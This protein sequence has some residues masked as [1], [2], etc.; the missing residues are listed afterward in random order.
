MA[1]RSHLFQLLLLA[2]ERV[3]DRLLLVLQAKNSTVSLGNF[4]SQGLN[5]VV[6]LSALLLELFSLQIVCSGRLVLEVGVAVLEL[7]QLTVLVVDLLLHHLA[8]LLQLVQDVVQVA[9]HGGLLVFKSIISI[10][11]VIGELSD[12]ILVFLDGRVQLLLEAQLLL[13]DSLL[14]AL[15]LLVMELLELVE[16]RLGLEGVVVDGL[17][18]LMLLLFE[19]LLQLLL[20]LLV[21]LFDGGDGVA[22][23]GFKLAELLQS[24]V[25]SLLSFDQLLLDDVSVL[26]VLAFLHLLR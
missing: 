22:L 8:F 21:P 6:Q 17:L 2:L 1:I 13:F 4:G 23:G 26:L 16:L 24:V 15:L 18:D 10:L 19:L 14:E 20:S 7:S 25:A 3:G 9:F 12:L 5:A 11:M